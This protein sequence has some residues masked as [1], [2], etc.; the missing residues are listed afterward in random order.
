MCYQTPNENY[1][2]PVA[3]P[4]QRPCGQNPRSLAC[5]CTANVLC[6]LVALLMAALGIILGAF[7]A[8]PLLANIAAVIVGAVLLAVLIIAILIYRACMNCR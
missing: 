5:L 8:V 7:F 4:A 2:Q 6:F 3:D 1:T